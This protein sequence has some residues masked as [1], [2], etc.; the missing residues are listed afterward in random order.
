MEEGGSIAGDSMHARGRQRH[1]P[2]LYL[3]VPAPVDADATTRLEVLKAPEINFAVL[4]LYG[5]SLVAL[6]YVLFLSHAAGVTWAQSKSIPDWKMVTFIVHGVLNA[7]LFVL[8]IVFSLRL[9][10]APRVAHE[11]IWTAALLAGGLFGANPLTDLES[12]LRLALGQESATGTPS[13]L[14]RGAA[15]VGAAAA[16]ALHSGGWRS[17]HAAHLV[18]FDA[19]YTVSVY[20]YLILS[21]HSYRI[22]Q[23][24][25]IS[26]RRFYMPKICAAASYFL[27]K[28]VVGLACRV[29][30]GLV[31]F[32]SVL[33]WIYLERS[34][35]HSSGLTVAVLGTAIVDSAFGLWVL[36]E[37]SMTASFLARVPY[38]ETRSKQLGFRCFVYQSLVFCVS[39]VTLGALLVI[40]LPREFLFVTYDWSLKPGKSRF[41]Q[42]EP[43]LGQLSLALV[44]VTWNLVLAYVNLPPGPIM[45]YT[46]EAIAKLAS[47]LPTFI[48]ARDRW[49]AWLPGSLPFGPDGDVE[50]EE[51][52]RSIRVG[53]GD[54]HNEFPTALNSRM[55]QGGSSNQVSRSQQRSASTSN[56]QLIPLRYRHREWHERTTFTVSVSNIAPFAP[57]GPTI[58]EDMFVGSRSGIP[59]DLWSDEAEAAS[60]V[61]YVN[62]WD[63]CLASPVQS[64]ASPIPV[65]MSAVPVSADLDDFGNGRPRGYSVEHAGDVVPRIAS[66]LP[67]SL[68]HMRGRLV[69]RK[70][71]FVMETQVTLANVSYLSYIPGN[72]SEERLLQ[73]RTPAPDASIVRKLDLSENSNNELLLGDMEDLEIQL[74]NEVEASRSTKGSVSGLPGEIK[75]DEAAPPV[76]Y[77]DGTMFMVDPYDVAL[78]HGYYLYRHISHVESNSHA[79]IVVGQDRVIVAFSGTR[80]TKNWVTNSRFGRVT[81]DEMFPRFEYE[82]L[83]DSIPEAMDGEKDGSGIGL[84]SSEEIS[85]SQDNG[86]GVA[87]PFDARLAGSPASSHVLSRAIPVPPASEPRRNRRSLRDNTGEMGHAHSYDE[88][89][90]LVRRSRS[91]QGI[92]SLRYASQNN[93][94]A[95]DTRSPDGGAMAV[96]SGGTYG[97]VDQRDKETGLAKGRD[98]LRGR[99]SASGRQGGAQPSSVR[100]RRRRPGEEEADFGR[101]AVALAE[102][103]VTYGQAKVHRGFAEAYGHLRKR[104]MGALMELYGGRGLASSRA[105]VPGDDGSSRYNRESLRGGV[106]SRTSGIFGGASSGSGGGGGGGGGPI[107]EYGKHGERA[108]VVRGSCAR[109]PLFLCGHSLGGSLATFASYE[110]ARYYRSVGLRRRQDVACTTFGAPMAGN[111]VFKARYERLVETHWRFEVAADPVPKL[112]GWLNYVPVGVR[113]LL[114]QSGMMLIDPSIVEVLWWGKLANP[115]LGY[116][117]HIRASYIMALRAYCTRYRNGD[118]TLDELFWAFPIKCQTRGLFPEV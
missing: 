37:I 98:S 77:D 67:V 114:D 29:A 26:S 41:L 113:V 90:S 48:R 28:V 89:S 95:G 84:L 74:G 111:S 76:P 97:S 115:Y 62:P 53:Q 93:L 16:A 118:D 19:A 105:E 25:L 96:P 15:A 68:P 22:L 1:G 85:A 44:Y 51:V 12:S 109:L 14:D 8:P 36:R 13:N 106:H 43:P 50:R 45:P 23:P 78:C 31:P 55:L 11:Q 49:P 54:D 56:L 46:A 65:P 72:P 34:G 73:R 75:Q 18:L 59:R 40:K 79:V 69:T 66:P 87:A 88:R 33:Q 60:E 42:L 6:L 100:R 82:K 70:N 10:I 64:R 71:L 104:V 94:V 38:L 20:M 63:S 80:D 92:S 108:G 86:E 5:A 9:S 81:W 61:P 91:E 47:M 103:L 32:I 4:S 117:L 24:H 30:L 2:P 27:F 107:F 110:C 35:R 101:Y 17:Q 58:C 99:S 52:S 7:T 21:A 116:K 39:I 112:S 102:E 83:D 57:A 3:P